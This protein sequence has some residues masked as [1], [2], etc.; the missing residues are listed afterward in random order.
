MRR[1]ASAGLLWFGG[2]LVEGLLECEGF[3]LD[4][5]AAR[6]GASWKR[7]ST[8]LARRLRVTFA[9]GVNHAS[10]RLFH[11]QVD[12]VHSYHACAL[13]Q[14]GVFAPRLLRGQP[15]APALLHVQVDPGATRACTARRLTRRRPPFRE[16]DRHAFA[17]R[18]TRCFCTRGQV[19]QVPA[20]YFATCS[21]A[22]WSMRAMSSSWEWMS[23]FW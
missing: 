11:A 21:R 7:A 14:S 20:A 9:C 19:Y 13:G 5:R 18:S 4:A 3:A 17:R 6:E 12:Q 8:R 10:S 2:V 15:G 1:P 23:S 16:V 22:S